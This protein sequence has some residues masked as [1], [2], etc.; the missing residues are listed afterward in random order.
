MRNK[1][2]LCFIHFVIAFII[3]TLSNYISKAQDDICPDAIAVREVYF[4]FPCP[5]IPTCVVRVVYCCYFDE[6]NLE[7]SWKIQQID[8]LGN[9]LPGSGWACYYVCYYYNKSEFWRRVD[10]AI[11]SDLY[12]ENN[13]CLS[14]LPDCDVGVYIKVKGYR[15]TCWYYENFWFTKY[16]PQWLLV[17]KPCG[18]MNCVHEYKICRRGNQIEVREDNWYVTAPPDCYGEEPTELPPPGKTW[19]E[20]WKTECFVVPCFPQ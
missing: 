4:A 7:L 1:I 17:M 9:G 12:W 3:L 18:V 6:I 14:W 15:S 13:P 2:H 19:E 20:Y 16:E 11:K 10:A 8:F 5:P